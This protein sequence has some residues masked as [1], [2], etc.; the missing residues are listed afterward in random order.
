M[1]MKILIPESELLL[2]TAEKLSQDMESPLLMSHLR[3]T[4]PFLPPNCTIPTTTTATLIIANY[5]LE[6]NNNQHRTY[7]L[8][9]SIWIPT[10]QR[11][12]HL[13]KSLVH[14]PWR[15]P[16]LHQVHLHLLEPPTQLLLIQVL[17]QFELPT[18]L[19]PSTQQFQFQHLSQLK[20]TATALFLLQHLNTPAPLS[21]I[22][23]SLLHLL[24]QWIIPILSQFKKLLWK[25]QNQSKF[26]L[27]ISLTKTQ[28]LLRL[29]I[30]PYQLK[31]IQAVWQIISSVR[32]NR[33]VF[34]F[35]Q[36]PSQAIQMARLPLSQSVKA[37]L[38]CLILQF[39]KQLTSHV[40]QLNNLM[41]VFHTLCLLRINTLTLYQIL[42]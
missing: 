14:P 35:L 38:L 5:S 29:R 22:N 15:H 32:S 33:Q 31:S 6:V 9:K 25:R 39:M 21:H 30:T 28:M 17:N 8:H 26:R 36:L 37:K 16:K 10:Q 2:P 27:V 23:P 1:T 13:C 3:N 34:Q 24:T 40:L 20:T 4:F 19:W 12:F 41:V 42:M 18:L 7:L 11:W